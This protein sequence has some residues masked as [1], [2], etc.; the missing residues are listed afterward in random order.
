MQTL[1][2]AAAK[3]G[4]GKTS[5]TAAIAVAANPDNPTLRIALIDLDP[6]GSLTLWWNRRASDRL[7]LIGPGNQPLVTVLAGL[8]RAGF[9]LVIVDC[10]PGFSPILA[11]AIAAA[12]LVVIPSGAGE[13]DRQAVAA[14]QA[15]AVTAGVPHCHVLNGVTF[16]SRLA[17]QAF[18][19][20]RALGGHPL[21]VVHRRVAVAEATGRGLTALESEPTGAAAREQAALWQALQLALA[22]PRTFGSGLL[23]RGAGTFGAG[24]FADHKAVN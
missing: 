7:S 10:P 15:M 11:A 23:V 3:G 18:L 22:R 19:A 24:V 4:V 2:L 16:R 5:L 1:V 20:M 12:T 6:Q 9:G 21:P 8:R 17:G 14:T 13:F